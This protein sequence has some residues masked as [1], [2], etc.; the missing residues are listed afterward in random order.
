MSQFEP[1]KNEQEREE[2]VSDIGAFMRSKSWG[3]IKANIIERCVQTLGAEQVGSLTAAS[4]HGTI[5]ALTEL[6]GEMNSILK[7]GRSNQSKGR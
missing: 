1:W 2:I 7:A 3:V 4:A 6:E 5:R